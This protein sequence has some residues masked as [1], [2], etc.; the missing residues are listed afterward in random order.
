METLRAPV[1]PHDH[2]QGPLNASLILLQY[3]DY[4]CP[5]CGMA[6]PIVK[7]VQRHFGAKLRFVF[8]NF[9]IPEAHPQALS[10]AQVA[11]FAAV[12]AKFWQMHDLLYE[13]QADLGPELYLALAE[14]LELSV[15]A[16]QN[17]LEQGSNRQRIEADVLG[18]E[19]SGVNG[20]P[21]FFINGK[22]HNASYEYDVLVTALNRAFQN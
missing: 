16:M 8:R 7:Q 3:G 1:S 19:R 14:K 13:N 21:T 9:P 17:A 4:E 20:T 11:E 10:A 22:R 2:A 5:Y 6:Y 15:A 18:G 12:H